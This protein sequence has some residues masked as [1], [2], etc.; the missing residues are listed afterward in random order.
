MWSR[1]V[2]PREINTLWSRVQV[3]S[4]EVVS[5]V[6]FYRA[7]VINSITTSGFPDSVMFHV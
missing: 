2:V 7:E 1:V 5:R 6:Q 4:R 3:W